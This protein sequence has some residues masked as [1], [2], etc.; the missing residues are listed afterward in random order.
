MDLMRATYDWQIRSVGF[1]VE[2]ALDQVDEL[3]TELRCVRTVLT[4]AS[5]CAS[6]S[7]CHGCQSFPSQS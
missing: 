6:S 5:I 3:A 2:L 1:D 4:D 7:G